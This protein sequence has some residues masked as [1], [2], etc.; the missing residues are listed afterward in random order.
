MTLPM[1]EG[2]FPLM[3][4]RDTGL[5]RNKSMAPNKHENMPKKFEY[6]LNLG[7]DGFLISNIYL[8][9]KVK[10]VDLRWLDKLTL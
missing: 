10:W 3:K 9:I 2:V 7:I 1:W 5:L 4:W 6:M 8:Y